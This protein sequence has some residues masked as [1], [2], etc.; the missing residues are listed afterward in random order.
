MRDHLGD[1]GAAA[2][3]AARSTPA[4]A[5]ASPGSSSSRPRPAWPCENSSRSGYARPA[6]RKIDAA[7]LGVVAGLHPGVD[8]RPVGSLTH[9]RAACSVRTMNSYSPVSGAR[10]EPSQRIENSCGLDLPRHRAVGAEVELHLRVDAVEQALVAAEVAGL[11]V[12]ALEAALV[13]RLGGRAEAPTRSATALRYWRDGEAGELDPRRLVAVSRAARGVERVVD[14]GGDRLR[15]RR[16]RRC[17]GR[18]PASSWRSASASC[19]TDLSPARGCV[20]CFVPSPVGPVAG[21]ALLLVDLLPGRLSRAGPAANV[22]APRS[23]RRAQAKRAG[24]RHGGW[25]AGGGDVG[26]VW[27]VWVVD[28]RESQA[29]RFT[30]RSSLHAVSRSSFRVHSAA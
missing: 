11:E 9:S 23:Q 21:G 18:P 4:P 8:Q 29:P 28:A 30:S 24:Q 2:S 13:V 3:T 26:E 14:V 15:V 12:L 25:Q 22:R 10:T 20:Y 7:E 6:S 16:R 1:A 19:A 17:R 27:L 5:A